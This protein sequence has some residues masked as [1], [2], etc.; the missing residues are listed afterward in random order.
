MTQYYQTDFLLIK[1]KLKIMDQLHHLPFTKLYG[2]IALQTGK[3]VT[4]S[5]GEI[6]TQMLH[7]ELQTVKRREMHIHH[8]CWTAKPS[9]V[10]R[11]TPVWNLP[12]L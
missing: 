6:S 2:E 12:T 11:Q 5:D 4:F 10:G 8:G 3:A 7:L 1:L 9:R